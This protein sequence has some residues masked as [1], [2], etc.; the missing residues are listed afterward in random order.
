MI[1]ALITAAAIA[2]AT[3][4]AAQST[5]DTRDNIIRFLNDEYGELLLG[6]GTAIHPQTR[7]VGI[8][9]MWAN[10]QTGT[11]SMTVTRADGAMC[12]IL[13]GQDWGPY[14]SLAPSGP[15]L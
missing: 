12:I 1:R 3:P 13:D 8:I 11:W 9:E 2:V 15:R 7:E 6:Q 10:G 4:A 14:E 5:C